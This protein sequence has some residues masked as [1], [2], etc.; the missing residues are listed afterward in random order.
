MDYSIGNERS[1]RV[2]PV[3]LLKYGANLR[4]AHFL[5]EKC[6]FGFDRG[7]MVSDGGNE[8]VIG[9]NTNNAA[10]QDSQQRVL[11]AE[12]FNWNAKTKVAT[13][14]MSDFGLK[15]GQLPRTFIIVSGSN[16]K[17]V[18]VELDGYVYQDR[19]FVCATYVDSKR[20]LTVK[21]FND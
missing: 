4:L 13:A 3:G 14:D 11:A 6:K 15:P 19:E 12:K 16:S 17:L 2:S 5:L 7:T 1:L 18:R 9:T 20:R 8:M 21:L 10:L